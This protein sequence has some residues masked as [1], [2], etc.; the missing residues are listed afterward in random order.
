MRIVHIITGL[1]R[2]GAEGA[3]FRLCAKQSD[4]SVTVVSLMDEGV[5]GPLLRKAGVDVYS[6]GMCSLGSVFRAIHRLRKFLRSQQP[7]VVQTWM[8]HADLIGGLV[9]WTLSIPVCWGIRNSG[10]AQG[11]K[12]STR[13]VIKA[14]A[15][16]SSFVPAKVISCSA[17]AVG[18]H[19]SLGYKGAFE[20]IPNGFAMATWLSKPGTKM[21]FEDLGFSSDSFVFAHAARAHPQ[22]DHATLAAAFSLA[23]E[24]NPSLKLLMC[25]DGLVKSSAYFESLPFSPSARNSVLALGARDDLPLL[26]Q[27][28]DGFVLSSVVEGFPNVVAEAMASGLPCVVTDAGDAAQIVGDTG[29]V[30]PVS[31]PSAL[32]AAMLEMSRMPV[33]DRAQLSSEARRRIADNFTVERMVDGFNRVWSDV[34]A[35]R[36]KACAG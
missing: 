35:E 32:G 36:R 34:A 26:W 7:D 13:L 2:G 14:C 5:Y 25:G 15:V 16:V 18:E 11:S 8:Y 27:R 23:H 31:H 12:W 33:G 30:V 4:N 28:V 22:K 10:A 24:R 6:L 3:L 21:S 20:V 1:N 9:A 29:Y 19:Q 17:R